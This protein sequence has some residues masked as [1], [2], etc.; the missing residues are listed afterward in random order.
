[1]NAVA[2]DQFGITREWLHTL[3]MALYAR[4]EFQTA[5]AESI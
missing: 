5:Y 2:G 3:F 4:K 1:M